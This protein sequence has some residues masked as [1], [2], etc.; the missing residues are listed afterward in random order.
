MSE[1]LY[2]SHINIPSFR[3]YIYDF[4]LNITDE[5]GLTVIVGANGLGKSTIINGIEWGLTGKIER[6][7]KVLATKTEKTRAVGSGASVKLKFNND[8]SVN[9][10]INLSAT[11]IN[12]LDDLIRSQ[13]INPGWRSIGDLSASL[14]FTHFRGQSALQHF[15]NQAGPERFHRL[16]GVSRLGDLIVAQQKLERKKTK[17]AFNN[18][19]KSFNEEIEKLL[20]RKQEFKELILQRKDLASLARAEKALSPEEV[21]ETLVGLKNKIYEIAIDISHLPNNIPNNDDIP[22]FFEKLQKAL[23]VN[24]IS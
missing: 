15:T 9:R 11:E 6:I 1:N 23:Q 19:E 18:I 21:R 20:K 14:Q 2:L 12:K 7:E 5:P 16:E 10:N 13:I 17:L 22:V 3:D 4:S 8:F 24:Q